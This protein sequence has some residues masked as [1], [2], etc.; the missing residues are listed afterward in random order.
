[1]SESATQVNTSVLF[2]LFS[3]ER[4]LSTAERELL[5]EVALALREIRYGTVVLTVHDGRIVELSKTERVRN[6]SP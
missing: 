1:M 4:G 6:T 5:R 3:W 2:D